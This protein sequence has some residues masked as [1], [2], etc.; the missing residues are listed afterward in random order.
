MDNDI[1]KHR[2]MPAE[3]ELIF[4]CMKDG[5][6]CL[7]PGNYGCEETPNDTYTIS[8]SFEEC[9]FGHGAIVHKTG[10][11]CPLCEIANL[12]KERDTLINVIVSLRE[13]VDTAR[14]LIESRLFNEDAIRGQDVL[15][16][17]GTVKG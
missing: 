1:C 17:L 3:G 9:E 7:Y 6:D 4:R 15:S 2:F 8:I 14:N 11:L 12:K 5:E 16:I 10:K 13:K